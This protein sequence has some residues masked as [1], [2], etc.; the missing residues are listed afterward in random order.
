MKIRY[1][2][3]LACMPIFCQQGSKFFESPDNLILL[4]ADLHTHTVFSDGMVWP[5]IRVQE[6]LRE[7]IEIIAITD[8]LEYQPKKQDIPNPDLNRSYIIAK[9]SVS[10]KDLI[11]LRGS[12]ITRDMPPGHFN[13]IF[14]KD[15]N[16]LLNLNDSIAGIIEA[17]K[18]G[19]FV[20]WNHPNWTSKNAG[21]IDGIARLDPLHKELISKNLIHGLEVANEDTFSEEALEIAIEN[22]LTIL[23]TSDIHGLVDWDF[24]IPNGGHRPLTFILSKDQSIES[25]KDALFN[26]DTFVWF[27]DLIIGKEESIL[28]IIKSNLNLKPLGYLGDTTLLEIEI[29][30]LS[31]MPFSLH[32]TG[33]YTFHKNSKFITIPKKSS[34]IIQ[35]K[36]VSKTSEI[37]L[38]FEILNAV[39]GLKESPK[40]DYN[41]KIQ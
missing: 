16:K 9:G 5:T 2:L 35:V 10:E 36:T 24:D 12:E 20:F 25:I 39:S 33:N 17:N 27:K 30:N 7:N 40:L 37:K 29:S 14:I 6:A 1:F 34:I 41:L 3:L 28:P 38:T 11:V 26:G 8:H 19:A 4:G 31:S 15:A 21:R 13:A 32:Y 18:Q 23:G 22:N